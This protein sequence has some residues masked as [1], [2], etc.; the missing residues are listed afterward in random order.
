MAGI[1][2]GVWDSGQTTHAPWTGRESREL[3][4]PL[5]RGE[6]WWEPKGRSRA[7]TAKTGKFL[8]YYRRCEHEVI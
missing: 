2:R 4:S 5:Q 3:A 8:D 7:G 1:R 6:L